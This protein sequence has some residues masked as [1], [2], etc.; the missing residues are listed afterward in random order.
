MIA[1]ILP[2]LSPISSST[3]ILSECRCC[4]RW[5]EALTVHRLDMDITFKVML[6]ISGIIDRYQR[7]LEHPHQQSSVWPRREEQGI[8]YERFGQGASPG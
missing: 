7:Y 6:A 8:R 4:L 3:M 2:Y 1:M 5:L